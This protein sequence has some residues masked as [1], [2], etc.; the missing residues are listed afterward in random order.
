MDLEL[1]DRDEC[2]SG[3][4]PQAGRHWPLI[5]VSGYHQRGIRRPATRLHFAYVCCSSRLVGACAVARAIEF[6]GREHF[7]PRSRAITEAV[8]HAPARRKPLRGTP[9][10]RNADPGPTRTPD[11]M[12]AAATANRCS[13][14][15]PLRRAPPR[16]PRQRILTI[17]GGRRRKQFVPLRISCRCSNKTLPD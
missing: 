4:E 10:W 3:V 9:G 2:A 11:T 6:K 15:P 1:L 12:P 5:S 17:P 8:I 14:G 16:P 13:S 7:I